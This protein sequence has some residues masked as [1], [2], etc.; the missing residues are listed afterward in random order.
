MQ[1][2][3]LCPFPLIRDPFECK[4]VGCVGPLLKTKLGNQ[5]VLT[6]TYAAARY[7]G[8]V[9]RR[10]NKAP[11]CV[12]HI[13]VNLEL[14]GPCETLRGEDGGTAQMHFSRFNRLAKGDHMKGFDELIRSVRR[15]T[16]FEKLR[17]KP[18]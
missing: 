7:P 14:K 6:K 16:T 2:A 3:T 12:T 5:Y 10:T 18:R 8:E 9:P 15:A 17:Q 1:S 11:T 4:L 13:G